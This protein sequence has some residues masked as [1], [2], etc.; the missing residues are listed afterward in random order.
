MMA[1]FSKSESA[2]MDRLKEKTNKEFEKKKF[3]FALGFLDENE[4]RIL[5]AIME[6]GGIKQDILALKTNLSGAKVS[7]ILSIFEKK[8]MITKEKMGNTYSIYLKMD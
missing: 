2:V 8:G 6:Q 5:K 1:L 7:K 4:K 3:D